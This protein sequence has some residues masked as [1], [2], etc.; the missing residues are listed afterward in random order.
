MRTKG[1][2]GAFRSLALAAGAGI[3]LV[4]GILAQQQPDIRFGVTGKAGNLR[5]AVPDF[6][7][8][9]V[10]ADVNGVFNQTLWNDLESSGVFEMVSKSL[11]PTQVPQR[12]EDFKPPLQPPAAPQR[13]LRAGQKPAPPPQPIS[14]GPWLT[15][16]SQPP[17][18]AQALAFGST[19]IQNDRFE[20]YGWLYDVTKSDTV[21]AQVLG[22]RYL[23]SNDSRGARSAA[24]EFACDILKSLG[25]GACIAGTRIYFVSNRTGGNNKEI[26]SMDFDGSNQTQITHYNS[27]SI[28]PQVSPDG[29]MIAFTSFA[30]GT[31]GIFIHSLET[32]RR[33][34]FYNQKASLN[35]SPSFSPDGQRIVFASSASGRAQI[36]IA[37]IDGSNLRRISNSLSIEVEPKFNPKTGNQIVFVSGRSGQPQIYLMDADGTNVQ[38]LTPSGGGDAVNPAWSPD[39]QRIAF[40]W[41]KGF[42]PGNYN[43]FIEEVATQAITQLT[44]GAGRNEH[45]SWAPDGRHIVFDSNREGGTQIWTMLADGTHLRKLT[46]QGRNEMPVWGVK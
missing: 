3:L 33:L 25:A 17:A 46:T 29:T 35:S 26:W 20:V 5:I 37:N 21:S 10:P 43:I 18:L 14:Q 39:G 45:P 31:P 16:W 19:A 27:I 42:E 7:G 4:A 11:Y 9:G 40:A 23:S 8:A 12:P 22:K 44:F 15:D 41:T 6:P 1:T 24:H 36:Y 38:K 32:N 28:S 30:R 13:R 34:T 2:T